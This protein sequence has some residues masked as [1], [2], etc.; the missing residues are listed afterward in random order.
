[1]KVHFIGIGGIGVSAIARMYLIAGARVTGSDREIHSPIIAELGRLGAIITRGHR[2][3]AVPRDADRVIYTTAISQ[4]NPELVRAEALG[5]K[6][7]SYPE[8]LGQISASRPTIAIAG[9]HGKTTTTAMVAE[10]LLLARRNPMVVVG[11][12]LKQSA[13]GRSN[14]IAGEGPL[15]VEACEYRR[16][17]LTL[18]PQVLVI[19]NIDNDHLDYYRD[20]ADI[21]NA[22]AELA[23]KIPPIG[24]LVCDVNDPRLTS[25]IQAA[26]CRV[27]DYRRFDRIA[28]K[29]ALRVIGVHNRW[30]AAAALAAGRAVRVP[31]ATSRRALERF[32]GTWRR[33]E[34]LGRT[35]RGAL[36]YDDYGHHPTAIRATLDAVRRELA[37]RRLFV[38]FQPHLYSR[39]KLLFRE[40]IDSFKEADEILVLPI[41]A[42]REPRDKT[43]SSRVLAEAMPRAIYAPNIAATK[44]RLAGAG[45]GDLILTLGAG[46][47][48]VLGE[49]LRYNHRTRT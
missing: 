41:Y 19:T 27:I 6:T 39:T 45:R 12:L 25:V 17:F 48:F 11:S 46:P 24:T 31:V 28:G 32:R 5:I 20:L 33:L 38:V 10:I 22:F 9:T 14:F 44:K 29:L 1:M 16:S 43:V 21:Q 7:L 42:A 40:F 23:G 13:G 34:Y 37:P 35:R 4:N 2:A 47:V 8:A 3:S 49:K 26:R 18:Q 15:V 36:I 30:N